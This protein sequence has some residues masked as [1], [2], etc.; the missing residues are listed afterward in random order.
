MKRHAFSLVSLLSLLLVAGSAIAQTSPVRANVP[1]D[2]TVAGKTVPAGTY[3]VGEL[4]QGHSPELLL[5]QSK[6]GLHMIIES[7]AAENGNGA[8]KTKLV[9]NRYKD[10]YFLS[11]IWVQ[12]ATSGRHIPKTGREKELARQMAS[13]NL[14]EQRVEI[15]AALY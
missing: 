5:L 2:F 1:F 7:N 14:T 6:D 8:N 12:R 15:V 3:T 13:A 11:E 9:F 10:Q 4:G